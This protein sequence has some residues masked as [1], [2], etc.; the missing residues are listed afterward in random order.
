MA[1]TGNNDVEKKVDI[2]SCKNN[3]SGVCQTLSISFSFSGSSKGHFIPILNPKK[4]NTY[5]AMH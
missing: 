3:R 4:M 5:K 2:A 1:Q